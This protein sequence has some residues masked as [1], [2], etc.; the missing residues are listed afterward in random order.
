MNKATAK[1]VNQKG[2]RFI[3]CPFYDGCLSYTAK[4][5]WKHW[6]C[7]SCPYQ[8]LEQIN[9]RMAYVADY[10]G[11]IAD[12]YPEFRQKYER[13]MRPELLVEAY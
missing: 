8:M 4:L 9:K 13:Y 11:V 1:P 12:V 3:D 2:I 10:Y 6:S 7:G 5:K